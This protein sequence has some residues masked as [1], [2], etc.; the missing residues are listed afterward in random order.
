MHHTRYPTAQ[1]HHFAFMPHPIN[2]C[3][4]S[5]MTPHYQL[6]ASAALQPTGGGAIHN[7]AMI[8]DKA[9]V[10]RLLDSGTDVDSKDGV[11]PRGSAGSVRES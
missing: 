2:I 10:K 4:A 8:G 6:T 1:H 9:E 5:H 7:A 3:N 11:S